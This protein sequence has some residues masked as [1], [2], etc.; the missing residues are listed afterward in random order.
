MAEAR[1]HPFAIRITSLD[2]L[3][4]PFDAR[5]VADRPLNYDVRVKLLDEWE[6]TR[7]TE[8]AFLTIHAPEEERERTDERAVAAAIG[9]D[10]DAASGSLSDVDPLSRSET[11]AAA[12]G[13]TVLFICIVASTWLDQQS[14]NVFLQAIS[15]AILLLGWVALWDPAARLVTETMPHFFNRRRFAEFADIE[16][17]FSWQ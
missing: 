16:V 7:A 9:N 15:Q 17:R 3:F 6:R 11:I 2:D 4:E 14:D 5:P 12:I 13:I 1:G 10:L 8:P